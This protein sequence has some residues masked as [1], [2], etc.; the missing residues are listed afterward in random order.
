MNSN[1][2][3]YAFLHI[4]P[5]EYTNSLNGGNQINVVLS[6]SA[7]YQQYDLEKIT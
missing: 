5:V 7:T 4:R 2:K 6:C 3:I 1:S